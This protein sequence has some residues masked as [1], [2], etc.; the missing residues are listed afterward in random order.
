MI[1]TL[2]EIFR[3]YMPGSGRS[4]LRSFRWLDQPG[5][6]D[7]AAWEDMSSRIHVAAQDNGSYPIRILPRV[8]TSWTTRPY[9]DSDCKEGWCLNWS[10][11][12]CVQGLIIVRQQQVSVGKQSCMLATGVHLLTGESMVKPLV[13]PLVVSSYEELLDIY[14]KATLLAIPYA[15]RGRVIE[16]LISRRLNGGRPVRYGFDPTLEF[17]FL[18]QRRVPIAEALLSVSAGSSTCFRSVPTRLNPRR[19]VKELHRLLAS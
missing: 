18:R 10:R 12:C 11:E 1:E 5:V 4:L 15:L 19:P 17:L 7:V 16:R 9:Q 14:D 8:Y 2:S 6:D 13:K 3:Q